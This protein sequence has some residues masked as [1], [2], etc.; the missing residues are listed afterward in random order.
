MTYE[1]EQAQFTAFTKALAELSKKHGVII[2]TVGGV[3]IVDTKEINLDNLEYTDDA[4][5]GDLHSTF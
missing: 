4:S 3:A 1:Q 2:N 5:S